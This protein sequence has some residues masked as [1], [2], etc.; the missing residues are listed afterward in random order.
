MSFDKI[1]NKIRSTKE[2][3]TRVKHRYGDVHFISFLGAVLS[4]LAYFDDNK[5]LDKYSQIMGPVIQPKIL[6]A[7]NNVASN[8]LGALLDDETIFGLNKTTTDIFSNY[9]YQF[10]GKNFIDFIN[11]NMPQNINIINGDLTGNLDLKIPGQKTVP[12]T[13]KYIS[14]SWSNYGEI[15]VVA[16]KRMSNTI[17]LIFRGP[18]SV[19]AAALFSNPS[20]LIPLTV[21]KD[22]QSKPETFLYGIFKASSEMIHTIIETIRYLATDFLGATT[23]NSVKIFTTGHSLGAAMCTN[24]AYL[25]MGIKKTYPYNS[26][27]YNVLADNLVCISLGS[28]RCMGDSVAKKFCDFAMEQKIL[29]L[30]ITTRGD[31]IVNLPYGTGFIHPCSYD[32]TNQKRKL[33]SE[34]CN[35]TLTMR[36]LPNVDYKAN[37]DCLDSEGR[38]YIRNPLSHTIYLDI[39]YTKAVDIVK[40]LSGINP[41]NIYKKGT[42][43]SQEVARGPDGSTICRLI[44]GQS[45]NYKAVFFD[46]N[47]SRVEPTDID[48]MLEGEL[49]KVDPNAAA[50]VKETNPDA[51][52][53]AATNPATTT[54]TNPATTTATNPDTTTATNP[55]TTNPVNPDTTTATNPT[56]PAT[57]NPVNPANPAAIQAGGGWFSWLCPKRAIMRDENAPDCSN[58]TSDATTP[59]NTNA[60]TPTNTNATTPTDTNAT[61]PTDTNATTPTN[62]NAT[63]PTILNRISKLTKIGG[64]VAEDRRVTNQAFNT[65]VQKMVPLQ[66]DNLSPLQG[67]IV[68]PFNNDVMPNLSCPGSKFT[69]GSKKR[70]RSYKS[71]TRKLKSR[72]LIKSKR[73]QT[74]RK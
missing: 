65:L 25:W 17:F 33:V 34:D 24:F 60:T 4:R 63:K 50:Q 70:G 21:C 61:T 69:G 58:T 26:S 7:I 47:K 71:V 39:M 54:A 64:E 66:Q 15:Y 19:K 11:L 42:V 35:A 3:L 41:V 13:V 16:D 51:T 27:P 57:T 10:R 44:M 74:R 38:V 31:P 36:P 55:A 49:N 53:P 9:E 59:T 37:L 48:A 32:K 45:G 2:D 1:I 29:Y 43:F 5:F 22:S 72:K 14:I 18:Y 6:Q 40:L 23:P 46:V 8:N 67:E 30:R 52:N 28:P 73:R 62:T 20:S 12:G 68:N 56:N